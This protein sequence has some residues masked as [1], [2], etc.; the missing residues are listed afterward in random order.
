MHALF[1][2]KGNKDMFGSKPEAIRQ[3]LTWD[4]HPSQARVFVWTSDEAMIN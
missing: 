1:T 4:R 2:T 3:K